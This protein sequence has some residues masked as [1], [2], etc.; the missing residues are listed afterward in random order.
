MMTAK[1]VE[2]YKM[3]EKRELTIW[4]RFLMARREVEVFPNKPFCVLVTNLT[5]ENVN[6]PKHSKSAKLTE[7]P[8][9]APNI[10]DDID[11]DRQGTQVEPVSACSVYKGKTTNENP[12]RQR[13]AVA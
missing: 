1:S 12:G 2:T 5:K 9:V 6:I 10:S 11:T 4:A 3:V 8:T 13:E 7:R